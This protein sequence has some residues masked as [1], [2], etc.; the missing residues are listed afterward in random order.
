MTKMKK[1]ELIEVTEP[2]LY[3]DVFPYDLP[4]RIIFDNKRVDFEVNISERDLRISDT[5][6]RDG[7]QARPP[8][9]VEQIVD[10]F[11]LLHKISGPNGIICASEFFVYSQ[12]DKDA[13]IAC[14]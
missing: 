3:E 9:T 14:M 4:P 1:Y 12:K 2:E 10:L 11:N 8:Y 7:Q 5:T 6:F 13:V